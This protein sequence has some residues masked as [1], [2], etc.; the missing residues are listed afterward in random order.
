MA[1]QTTN[2]SWNMPAIN[3]DE[4]AWGSYLNNNINSLD[5]LLGGVDNT[6][7]QI[8]NGAT[9]TTAELNYLDG[10]TSAVQTQLNAKTG[11][12]ADLSVSS[13]AAELNTLDAVSRGSLIYGNSS[14]A[15]ALLTKGTANQILTSDGTDISWQNASSGGGLTQLA[16]LDANNADTFTFTGLPAT[17]KMFVLTFY[18]PNAQG[19]N[20]VRLSNDSSMITS[21]Y[22]TIL[23]QGTSG[24]APIT[25][26]ESGGIAKT[27]NTSGSE[28][29]TGQIIIT[30]ADG[31][32][33]STFD[34]T[35]QS[36]IG[37]GDNILNLVSGNIT[38]PAVLERI[39]ID[40]NG[41]ST[42]GDVTLY[43]V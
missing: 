5:S 23:I 17:A 13:T 6:E 25:R 28:V 3:G 20:Y 9:V 14:G 35:A 29:V 34:Y 18:A 36:S 38:L 11:S 16:T 42:E 24:Q 43:G 32:S 19:V 26:D 22:Q 41:N 31:T 12:L 4:D 21:G 10:V 15:T 7:F 2:Y 27:Q 1:T 8:L 39:E 33:G 40:F 37:I 30:R